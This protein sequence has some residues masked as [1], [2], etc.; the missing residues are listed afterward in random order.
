VLLLHTVLLLPALD[1]TS[2]SLITVVLLALQLPKVTVHLNLLSPKLKPLTA[3][4]ALLGVATVAPPESTLQLPRPCVGLVPFKLDALLQL[5]TVVPASE[6]T[7]LFCTNRSALNVQLLF[8]T[9]QVK[10]LLPWP[11][12]VTELFATAGC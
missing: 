7:L 3:L 1:V 2:S 6:T 12:P 8:L 4:V 11:K 10:M 5:E 9:V